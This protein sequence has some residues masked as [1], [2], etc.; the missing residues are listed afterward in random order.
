MALIRQVLYPAISGSVIKQGG[1]YVGYPGV[2][3][4]MK[5]IQSVIPTGTINSISGKY[6]ADFLD[7]WMYTKW[8]S[9]TG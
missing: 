4:P 9:P 2:N 1:A 7:P 8:A 6:S 3:P 5:T